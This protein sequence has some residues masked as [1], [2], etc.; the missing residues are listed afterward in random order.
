MIDGPAFQERLAGYGEQQVR[1]KLAAGHFGE[2][3]KSL[4]EDWLRQQE[5]VPVATR[6]WRGTDPV[7]L[8]QPSAGDLAYRNAFAAD[9]DLNPFEEAVLLQ[10][11][12]DAYLSVLV[13]ENIGERSAGY[14]AMLDAELVRRGSAIAH[15]ANRIAWISLAV[16]IASVIIS[17]LFD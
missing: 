15:R 10:D 17:V 2:A 13:S 8:Y 11:I 4:V 7:A 9:P 3:K 5:A 1:Q 16:A 6:V 14:R 12:S